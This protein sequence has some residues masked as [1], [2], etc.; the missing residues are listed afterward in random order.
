[1]PLT[2]LVANGPLAVLSLVRPGGNRISFDMRRELRA[3]AE[4]STSGKS[5][6]PARV[7]K[8]TIFTDDLGNP[9]GVLGEI[10]FRERLDAVTCKPAA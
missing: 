4:L 5:R 1:M 10:C 6:K 8:R 3:A 7:K 2:H 9:M